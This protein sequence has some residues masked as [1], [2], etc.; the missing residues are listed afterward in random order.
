ML[1]FPGEFVSDEKADEIV[2][3]YLN[4]RL[5]G[6][7][8]DIILMYEAGGYNAIGENDNA[9]VKY[10]SIY[11]PESYPR[12]KIGKSF[13]GLY[14]LL[15]V[16]DN[17][18]PELAMEY[19]M[20]AVIQSVIEECEDTGIST[21]IEMPEREYV[22]SKLKEDYTDVGDDDLKAEDVLRDYEDLNEFIE[23]CFW[24]VDFL[25]LDDYTE[26]ELKNSPLND[27]LGILDDKQE[28]TFDVPTTW[29]E[30]KQGDGSSVWQE[31]NKGNR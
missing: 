12:E 14:A 1:R 28:N 10:V 6:M 17:F 27:M 24:D 25:L 30:N 22:L 19:A 31:K 9:F 29:L 8:D 3:N 2:R 13:L 18:V 26:E 11:F 16:E 5:I 7:M 4:Q 21:I 20:Y 23:H 15:T